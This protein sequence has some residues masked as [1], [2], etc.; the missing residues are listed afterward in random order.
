MTWLDYD[1][2]LHRF[3]QNEDHHIWIFY[4]FN[5][6]T[7]PHFGYQGSILKATD[8]VLLQFVPLGHPLDMDSNDDEEAVFPSNFSYCRPI[9]HIMEHELLGL[10]Y[11]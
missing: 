10:P 4:N 2:T 3:N 1:V 11:Y 7:H 5:D 6:R 9:Q 8:N